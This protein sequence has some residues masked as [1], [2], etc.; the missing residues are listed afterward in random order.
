MLLAIEGID[1]SGKGTQTRLLIEKLRAS[2][3]TAASVSFPRYGETGSSK[4][5]ARYLNGELGRLDDVSPYRAAAMFALDRLESRAYLELLLE[6]HDIVV[7]DRYVGSNL[8]YQSARAPEDQRRHLLE[9]INRL[10]YGIN[11]L[12]KPQATFYLDV[13]PSVA[14]RHVSRKEPRAYTKNTHDFHEK[15]YSLQGRAKLGY[16]HLTETGYLGGKCYGVYCTN[17]DGTVITAEEV[18]I[19]LLGMVHSF[20][21]D[22]GQ[23]E[24][25][26]RAVR[27]LK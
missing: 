9:W 21:Q 25:F 20:L 24:P 23:S 10:E 7:A 26:K 12:P 17:M 15:D 1:G 5:I 6:K 19:S 27:R 16:R 11:G 22:Y 18:H 13:P 3:R 14:A 4:L 2:G 8:A